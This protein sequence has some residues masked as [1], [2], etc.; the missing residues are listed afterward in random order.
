M[1]ISLIITTYNRVHLLKRTYL[2]ILH[3]TFQ[4][5]EL[6]IA[7]DGSSEDIVGGIQALVQ[8]SDFKVKFVQQEDKGFRA[9]RCR[10]NGIRQAEG[11]YIVCFDPDIIFSK[12]Y[13]KTMIGAAEQNRFVVGQVIRLTEE[14]N[15][16]IT[17]A[18]IASGDFSSILTAPQKEI[19]PR[20]YRKERFYSVMHALKLRKQG[21][22]LR[23]G[24]VGFF[25]ADF[26]KVNGFDEKFVGWGN[27]DDDLGVRFYAAG[28]KGKNPF[29]K[30]YAVH[31][32]HEAFHSGE[33]V[34]R[35]YQKERKK[36]ITKYN[37]RCEHGYDEMDN[38]D[39][40][41]TVEILK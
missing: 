40:M 30:E 27:E 2:S 20:Q 16:R 33:R 19:I 26:I 11:D 41:V 37:Y 25:K 24:L 23:S 28:I 9:A 4:P 31:L 1:K 7:D 29:K 34:N 36:E 12:H 32:Y 13:L 38:A 10:N 17:H 6:I 21:P 8:Q 15:D 18:H 39:E 14:Q 35:S 3:Q 22:K 5:D